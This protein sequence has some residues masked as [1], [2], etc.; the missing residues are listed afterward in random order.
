MEIKMIMMMMMNLVSF[1]QDGLMRSWLKIGRTAILD[2]IRRNFTFYEY[3]SPQHHMDGG[4]EMWSGWG[5]CG[6]Y[7]ESC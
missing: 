4:L 2:Y 3:I 1:L 6:M 5:R 7:E